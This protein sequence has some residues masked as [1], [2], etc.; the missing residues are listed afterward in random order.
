M[1]KIHAWREWIK[2]NIMMKPK[3]SR[4]QFIKIAGIL[5]LLL[6]VIIAGI[7]GWPYLLT[8]LGF[9]ET[10]SSTQS[11]QLADVLSIGEADTPEENGTGQLTDTQNSAL[12]EQIEKSGI[13]VFS[14]ADGIHDSLF[15]YHPQ[16]LTYKRI[17]NPNTDDIDPAIS[18]DG[19]K[20][21]FSSRRNGYW[22]IYILNMSDASLTKVTDTPEYEG[23][24]SWSP[25]GKW[26]VY[27]KYQANNF[28]L[29][30]QALDASEAPINLTQ[31]P[32]NE[33]SPKWSP[34]GGFLT[35]LSDE[36]GSVD[37]WMADL[38]N[39]EERFT[40]ITNSDSIE[41]KNP[42]WNPAGTTVAWSATVNGFTG[43][44]Q[45]NVDSKET[46]PP[47]ASGDLFV[48]SPDQNLILSIQELA[49]GSSLNFY[50]QNGK[51]AYP[52][53]FSQ[54]TIQGVDWSGA[55]F[56]D[57]VIH[58][59]FDS[60]SDD[61]QANLWT[62]EIDTYPLPPS[63]RYAVVPLTDVSAPY[64]YLHDLAD[65]SF[66]QLRKIIA[67]KAGW[68]VLNSL[69]NAFIPITVPSDIWNQDNWFYTGRAI[70]IN[71]SPVGAGWMVMQKEEINAK[72]YWRIF[73]K[74]R[75][76]DGS[77]GLPLKAR[78]FNLDARMEGNPEIY[79][80]GG[81]LNDIPSGYWIDFTDL[82]YRFSWERISAM[83]QWETY[84][85]AARDNVFI[86]RQDLDWSQAMQ[87][88]IPVELVPTQ[89]YSDKQPETRPFVINT[90]MPE[91]TPTENNP[92]AIRPTW[93]PVPDFTKP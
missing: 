91:V 38:N 32:Y 70:A 82:A 29:Y 17:T 24:P 88:V 39:T 63:G 43:I 80:Q 54:Q 22:D 25:D 27:E 19:S 51:T 93:T 21:A 52:S 31:T 72:I 75:Y 64:P 47:T 92:A 83:I 34:N 28:D 59:P 15:L 45:Y 86:F 9:S 14:M 81:V 56:V 68:D 42:T 44:Y 6:I 46:I 11:N 78:V 30:I 62:P 8:W 33:F 23:H 26:L 79:D 53:Q 3:R 55:A 57:Q 41:E 74:C 12:F 7:I 90:E 61:P 37:V 48:W 13:V 36:A 50:Q 58:Y 20:I 67:K 76:Q 71:T 18:P 35:Y 89:M 1:R 2:I 16:Y 84:F 10:A 69:E 60:F 77:Q 4:S 87:E 49:N 5:F 73:V 40:N 85:P 66:D 65:E